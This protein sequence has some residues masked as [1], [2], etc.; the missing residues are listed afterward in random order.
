MKKYFKILILM[1]L[2]PSLFIFSSCKK[3]SEDPDTPQTGVSHVM[4]SAE[5]IVYVSELKNLP[6]GEAIGEKVVYT[7]PADWRFTSLSVSPSGNIG[8][9]ALF[10][11]ADSDSKKYEGNI[12]IYNLSENKLLKE[13]NKA[14]FINM[15][16]YPVSEASMFVVKMFWMDNDKL[17]IHMQPQT[18]WIGSLPQNV[19]LIVDIKTDA[20]IEKKY[21]D[22]NGPYA[23]T[24]PDH[25]SKTKYAAEIVSQS[26]FING[27]KVQ[28]LRTI[29][30][31]DLAFND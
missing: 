16:E 15:L 18:S 28:N 17:L 6:P 21:S 5:K 13:F 27:S 7:I 1:A 29:A 31:F 20:V 11:N 23:I 9:L 19:S 22:R 4:Y 10:S 14:D 3:K 2:V 12:K 8:T 25:L 26:L 30:A 24:A